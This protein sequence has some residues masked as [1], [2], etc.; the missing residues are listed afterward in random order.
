MF[1][2]QGQLN[3]VLSIADAMRSRMTMFILLTLMFSFLQGSINNVSNFEA[4]APEV[5]DW[6]EGG[7][8]YD[9]LVT[10]TQFG[11]RKI[12]TTA[13]ENS[14]NWIAAQLESYGYQ[15]ERQSFTTDECANCQNIVVTINGTLDDEWIVVGA[16]HD[17]ICYSPPP[18]IGFTYPTCTS[19]GA[20]DD[21]TGSGALLELARTFALWDITP[22][23]TWKLAWWD[24]EEWQGSASSEGGGKGSLHFVEQQIPEN[25]NVTYLN[26]DMFALNWPV[27][28]PA[29]MQIGCNEDYWTLYM[30]TSPVEDWSYYEERGLEVT[31]K[32]EENAVV[33]QNRLK[34]INA[35]LSHPTQWVSVVD[36]TKGNSDHYNFIMN[37]H[38]ATWLR[39]Q[40]QYIIEEGD[41]CEQTPKHAQSD[42]VTTLNTM[43]GGRT[44][45]ESGLQT[46]LD[47]IAT[48]ALWY[49]NSSA[50]SSDEVV[51]AQASQGVNSA[52]AIIVML[53]VT[54]IFC[55][56]IYRREKDTFCEKET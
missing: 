44:N 6:P 33:L 30:F 24:Y 14:R 13:N 22:Q 9:N 3:H 7:N 19:S 17:A 2:G 41:S 39:G 12:D 52:I 5:T 18:L 50:D 45:V 8:A 35:N 15:V 47:V 38:S 16:H 28:M 51:I 31:P 29:A 11:Y 21:A 48:M 37:G 26:L 23:H 40:H 36:D 56:V 4:E 46:G 55:M 32:M 10:M 25:T 34:D 49:R 42:S 1:L 43:A 53:I 27:E 54:T 20:Y